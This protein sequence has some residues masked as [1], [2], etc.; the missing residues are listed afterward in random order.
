MKKNRQIGS[1]TV[2]YLLVSGAVT[3]L[4]WTGVFG[5]DGLSSGSDLDVGGGSVYDAMRMEYR[6]YAIVIAEQ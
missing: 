5:L 6:S 4:V 2:E 1:I 3:L